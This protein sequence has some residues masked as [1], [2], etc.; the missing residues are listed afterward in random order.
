M[1]RNREAVAS[2]N[3]K[4]PEQIPP[5]EIT[6]A[7]EEVIKANIGIESE[8][9]MREVGRLL[10]FRSTSAKLKDAIAPVMK[11]LCETHGFEIRQGRI[12]VT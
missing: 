5:A 9:A 8:D 12:Y 3:L 11:T 4:K 2:A 7:L 1:V 10:G 6:A